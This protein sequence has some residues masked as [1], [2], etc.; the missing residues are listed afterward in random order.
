MLAQTENHEEKGLAP[1]D[2]LIARVSEAT[3]LDTAT[4]RSAVATI[5]AFLEREAPAADVAAVFE[6][7][8]GADELA[9]E[10]SGDDIGLM[11]GM[12]GGLMVLAG[13][14]TALGLSMS[15]MQ[16]L[17]RE[18]FAFGREKAGEDKMGALVGA[19]PGLSQFV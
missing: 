15:D 2:E 8:P 13:Q 19:V 16:T 11:G 5:L 18:V 14:L 3:G 6:A 12:G 17:G 10:V 7:L 4:A 9:A 1:M